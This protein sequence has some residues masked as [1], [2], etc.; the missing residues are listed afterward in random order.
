MLFTNHLNK[1]YLFGKICYFVTVIKFEMK[2]QFSISFPSQRLMN[3]GPDISD[4]I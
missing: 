3:Q 4:Y 1:L 2:P